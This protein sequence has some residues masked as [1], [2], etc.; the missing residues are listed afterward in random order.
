M[1]FKLVEA[2]ERSW[3]RVDGP[4]KLPQVVLGAKLTDGLEVAT[5][6]DRQPEVA[7]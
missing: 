3:R 2:V 4:N 6:H 5:P 7:A 1:I